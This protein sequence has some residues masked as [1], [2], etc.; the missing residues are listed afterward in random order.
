MIFIYDAEMIGTHSQN[1]EFV[2][3]YFEDFSNGECIFHKYVLPERGE[4]IQ[5]YYNRELLIEKGEVMEDIKEE[6]QGLFDLCEKPRFIS[7]NADMYD[8]FIFK[9]Y[10]LFKNPY[11]FIMIDT[12]KLLKN[13]MD[14][15]IENLEIMDI[16]EDIF[17]Y[18]KD[19][20]SSKEQVTMLKMILEQAKI[21]K[22]DIGMIMNST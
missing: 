19:E 3:L 13:Y 15:D 2:Q 20:T 9:K 18:V 5:S 8:Q 4:N 21:H 22:E 14:G 6:I 1:T 17:G 10:G 16:V 12:R 11:L 7:H